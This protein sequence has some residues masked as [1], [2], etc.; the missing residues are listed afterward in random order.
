MRGSGE[1]RGRK[2]WLLCVVAITLAFFAVEGVD[3][4]KVKEIKQ[5]TNTT[6]QEEVNPKFSPDGTK[7]AYER[8]NYTY[9]EFS[10]T[11]WMCYPKEFS[12]IWVMDA[13]G[14]NRFM[15]GGFI[16]P[17]RTVAVN[18]INSRLFGATTAKK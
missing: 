15:V 1:R 7:I 14:K 17:N 9:C 4:V 13:E 5:L 16:A 10:I 11:S 3:A 2:I 6:D 18:Q 8:R 12:S